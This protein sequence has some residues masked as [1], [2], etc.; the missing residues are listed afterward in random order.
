M[1]EEGVVRG[2][3]VVQSYDPE[4]RYTEGDCALLGY[5]AQHLLTALAR[6]DAQEE[7][8][9]RVDER[10]RE[11]REQIAE[12]ERSERLRA[13]LFRIAEQASRSESVDAFYAEVHGI[14]SGLLD[15]RNF[16]IALLTADGQ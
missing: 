11:L 14:V 5:V 6:R 8:E 1:V 15:A 16:F 4:W 3:V 7:L 12:R 2:A 13:A 10:T 9:R